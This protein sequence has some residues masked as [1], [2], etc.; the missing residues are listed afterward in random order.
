MCSTR[1]FVKLHLQFLLV[2]LLFLLPP[3]AAAPVSRDG[4]AYTIYFHNQPPNAAGH[5]NFEFQTS[6][7]ITTKGAGNEF[8]AVGVVQY[9][10]LEGLPI[11][12]TYTA[13]ENG[14]QPQG[15]HL[16]AVPDYVQ[17]SL[18]YIRTHEPVNELKSR[19]L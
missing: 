17:R 9:V 10:S 15:E 12:L 18:E 16:P 8:G 7:G 19:R 6:N 5:Y 13:D 4:T 1:F 14:Y 11:T 3:S 2:P